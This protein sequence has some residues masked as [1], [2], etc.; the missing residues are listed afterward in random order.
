AITLA[1]KLGAVVYTTASSQ[2]KRDYLMNEMGIP[3]THIFSSRDPSFVQAVMQAT[4]GRGVDV[5]IN[6]L[7]GDLMHES[8]RCLAEFGRFVE[9]GKRELLDAG[10]LD[11]RVFLRNAT[12][13][14]FDL[15]ELFYAR[16]PFHRAIWD[17][18]MVETL[19]LYRAGE[20]RPLPMR[21]FDSSRVAQAYQYF[22]N[23]D[24]VGKVVIS[25]EDPRARVPVAPATYLS[26]FDAEKVYLLVGC[27]GGLGR[28]LS[29][30]MM[31]RGARHFVFL[32]RSGADKPSAKQL[33]SRLEEAGATVGIVRGDVSKAADVTAAVSAC[34][35]TGR[36]IG[37][38]IQ[39]A[40]GLHEALFTRMPNEAWHTGIDPKWQGTWNLHN[41]LQ[42]HV[43][44][45]PQ[46]E[47]DFFLLTSSVSGTV[48]TATESNY[49]SANGFLD[50]FA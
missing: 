24:R 26:V 32:G 33:V 37:G 38:V 29:R 15:S 42:V 1:Q 8:W 13:T 11:M 48:G 9:I 7:V 5:V 18:L 17:R 49:C 46:N 47:P 23:K 43:D 41:A 3:P 30:W 21:V 14:A 28:S 45:D 20:I 16:D 25:F 4:G 50:A 10:K 40:M 39:A 35:A 6:S 36:R 34:V 2:T 12:F 31:A 27:L 19:Q 22:S 44:N